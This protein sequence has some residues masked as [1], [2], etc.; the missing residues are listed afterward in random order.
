MLVFGVKYRLGLIDPRWQKQ[1]Y[2]VMVN[3]A[4]EQ[5][6]TVVAIGG[7]KDHVHILLSLSG[8]SP[9]IA[10]ITREIK[11][12]SSKWVNENRLCMGR[13]GWQSGSGRFSYSYRELEMI[14]NYINNQERHHYD[15]D[16]SEEFKR[17]MQAAGYTVRDENTP[18]TLI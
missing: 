2:A 17:F 4:K 10:T 11:S 8:S 1:L 18:E 13:F 12:K 5:K 6:C 14:K 16:Y 15:M 7:I 3:I 9:D